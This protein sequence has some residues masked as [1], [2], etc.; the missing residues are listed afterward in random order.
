MDVQEQ[1]ELLRRQYLQLQD[2]ATLVLPAPSLLKR[3]STQ[4]SIYGSMF[5]DDSLVHP[6]PAAY[7][8]RVLKRLVSC[9]ERAMDDPDEDVRLSLPRSD[10][11][12][13]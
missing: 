12:G 8:L 5:R 11:A 6:P 2:P 7:R 3:P 13:V 4:E 10:P 9:L 1:I